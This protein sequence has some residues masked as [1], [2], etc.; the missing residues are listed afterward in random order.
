M[1]SALRLQDVIVDAAAATCVGAP[2]WMKR[3]RD[4][5]A[6]VIAEGER[7]QA[8]ASELSDDLRR[9][10]DAHLA[11]VTATREREGELDDYDERAQHAGST[12][13]MADE[14]IVRLREALRLAQEKIDELLAECCQ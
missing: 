10:Q 5:S 1:R 12:I 3:L 2:N 9:E 13:D 7:W 6:A 8:R 14:E 11:L 4:A